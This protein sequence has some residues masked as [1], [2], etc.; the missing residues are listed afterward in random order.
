MGRRA[1]RARSYLDFS[2]R[3]LVLRLSMPLDVVSPVALVAAPRRHAEVHLLH[4]SSGAAP[5]GGALV[6]AHPPDANV[7][8]HLFVRAPV[9]RAAR[10]GGGLAAHSPA[11]AVL[12]NAVDPERRAVVILAAAPARSGEESRRG[13]RGGRIPRVSRR[14]SSDA[15]KRSGS[16]R[17][18]RR[19][20]VLEIGG[21]GSDAVSLCGKG[22]RRREVGVQ[23]AALCRRAHVQGAAG[24]RRWRR[25]QR[26]GGRGRESCWHLLAGSEDLQNR[27]PFLSSVPLQQQALVYVH[28]LT[29]TI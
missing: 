14:A 17:R 9:W 12:K 3:L 27:N 13:R 24:R 20:Y 7:V 21:L 18:R 2:R 28:F 1:A 29:L 6:V 5:I 23:P 10:P 8:L 4:L 11:A 19:S 26:N 25:R 22:Q 16:R 15:E